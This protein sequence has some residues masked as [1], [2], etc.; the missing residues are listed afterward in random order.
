MQ[1]QRGTITG[2]QEGSGRYAVQLSNGQAMGL[3]PAKVELPIGTRVTLQ[4]LSSEQH[5]GARGEIMQYDEEAGRYVIKTMR[6]AA[7][8][9]K[10]ENVK[11]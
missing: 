5:N 9:V 7:L 8:K 6:G 4:G 10:R 2:W 11:A 1:G 3:L